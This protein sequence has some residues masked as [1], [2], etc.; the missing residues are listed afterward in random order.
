LDNNFSTGEFAGFGHNAS[1]I[2]GL[3]Y[4]DAAKLQ[5]GFEWIVMPACA[6]MTG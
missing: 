3:L 2:G 6:G 1:F 5:M 4:Q